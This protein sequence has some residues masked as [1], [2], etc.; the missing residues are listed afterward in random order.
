MNVSRFNKYTVTLPHRGK[1]NRRRL[2]M[3]SLRLQ[4]ECLTIITTCETL[5]TR[6]DMLRDDFDNKRI[7]EQFYIG[8]FLVIIEQYKELLGGFG[9]NVD[10]LSQYGNNTAAGADRQ[11]DKNMPFDDNEDKVEIIINLYRLLR[12]NYNSILDFFNM[13]LSM[14]LNTNGKGRFNIL[15]RRNAD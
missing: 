15:G 11:M 14:Y 1:R 10:L 8:C 6:Y 9:D 2:Q 13:S 3:D 4:N 5:L 12:K 7:G